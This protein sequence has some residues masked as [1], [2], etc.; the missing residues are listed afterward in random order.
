MTRGRQPAE[1]TPFKLGRKI[2]ETRRSIAPRESKSKEKGGRS[3]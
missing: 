2:K 3:T 1:G